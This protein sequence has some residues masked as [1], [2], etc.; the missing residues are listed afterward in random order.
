MPT[1]LIGALGGLA[2]A[3]PA[4]SFGWWLRGRHQGGHNYSCFPFGHRWTQY[5][6]TM[7]VTEANGNPVVTQ[8]RQCRHC[9][10]VDYRRVAIHN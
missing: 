4:Y 3:L 9:N 10:A 6:G 2:L 5:A 1:E 8:R 7:T